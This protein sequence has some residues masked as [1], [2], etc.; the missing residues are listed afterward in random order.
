MPG[1]RFDECLIREIKEETGLDVKVGQPFFVGEWRPV[2]KGEPWQVIGIFFECFADSDAVVLSEDHNEYKW[3]DPK[4]YLNEN[5]IPG[6][7]GRFDLSDVFKAYL[8]GR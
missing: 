7:K 1:E 6:G 2:V 3:I 5:L 8:E 4:N